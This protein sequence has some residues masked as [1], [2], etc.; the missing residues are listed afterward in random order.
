MRNKEVVERSEVAGGA[1]GP[2]MKDALSGGNHVRWVVGSGR[3]LLPSVA[4]DSNH[5]T[6]N[7]IS[8]HSF[9]LLLF[10]FLLLIYEYS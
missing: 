9:I 6:K 10:F 1:A 2:F 7:S 8:I 4:L 3:K 5:L